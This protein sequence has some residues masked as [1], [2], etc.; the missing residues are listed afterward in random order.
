MSWRIPLVELTLEEED[1][2]AYLDSLQSGWWTMGP[3]TERFERE[4]ESATGAEH[5]AAVSSGTAALHLACVAADLGPGDEVIVPAL[6]FVATAHA[7]RYVG[8]EPVLCDAGGSLDPNVTAE[9]VEPAITDRTRA[10]ICVHLYGTACDLEGLRALCDERELVLIEDCAQSL[11]ATAAG[12]EQ[13]G[14]VGDYGCFSFFSKQQLSVGEGGMVTARDG[15]AGERIRR[16]RSH[17]RTTSTWDRHV[18]A[19]VGYDVTELGFNYR[20]DEPHAALGISRLARVEAELGRRRPLAAIYRDGVEQ[21]DG[22]DACFDASSDSRSALYAFPIVLRDAETREQVRAHLA[23]EGIQTTGYPSLAQL[24][25]YRSARTGGDLEHASD[26][27]VRSLGLPLYGAIG[28]DG[29]RLVLRELGQALAG[30]S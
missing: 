10:V 4:F 9:S 15:E 8:A 2:R 1:V 3:T 25:E 12:G 20:L 6:T 7:A 22:A 19:A 14:T 5:A 24:T 11:G 13:T 29:V 17:G 16:L 23:E 18:G 26:L 21:I 27:T 28:E 30:R